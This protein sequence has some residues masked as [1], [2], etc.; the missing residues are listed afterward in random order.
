M[1]PPIAGSH[2]VQRQ[3]MWEERKSSNSSASDFMYQNYKTN[4]TQDQRKMIE[5]Q[6]EMHLQQRVAV[7]R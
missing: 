1:F 6:Y 7:S 4:S 3:N 2:N 5:E